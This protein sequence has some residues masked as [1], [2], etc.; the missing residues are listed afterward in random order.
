V[1][2]VIDP[3]ARERELN[4]LSTVTVSVVIAILTMTFGAMIAVFF[5]RSQYPKFW[6]HLT[7]PGVLWLTTAILLA[8][9]FTFERARHYLRLK[10]QAN[11]YFMM[12]V[13]TGLGLAFLVGQLVAWF[14]ILHS[15]LVLAKNPHS[16][17]IFLFSGLHGIHIV[18]GLIG[19]VYLLLRTR[20]GASGPKYQMNTRVVA[21][22]VS[23]AW[24]YLDF[25]WLV[26]FSLLLVWKR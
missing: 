10:E 1:Q 26:M 17:F 6:G 7:I 20:R 11:A 18:I 5:Y 8:S 22:G 25:L 19:L 2:T 16:W 9:S 14:Q 15:G 13:T 4:S 21:R 23:I 3:A 12:K 24:H